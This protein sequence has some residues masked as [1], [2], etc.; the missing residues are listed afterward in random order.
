MHGHGLLAVP[1][2]CRSSHRPIMSKVSYTRLKA[3]NEILPNTQNL[4]VPLSGN[5]QTSLAG[6]HW[7]IQNGT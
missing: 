1:M 2:C 7:A 6:S 5:D 3:R 4:A